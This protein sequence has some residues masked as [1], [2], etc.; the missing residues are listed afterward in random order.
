MTPLMKD[1][2][3]AEDLRDVILGEELDWNAFKL[4]AVYQCPYSEDHPVIKMFW[5]VFDEFEE[6]DKRQFLKFLTGADH[7]PVGGFVRFH[8]R[9]LN[10]MADKYRD[11]VVPNKFPEPGTLMPEV[12]T[13]RGFLSLDIP[14]YQT[15]E[16][17]RFRLKMAIQTSGFH[18]EAPH[19]SSATAPCSESPMLRQVVQAGVQL[20]L[21]G[22]R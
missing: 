7:V 6:N 8:V 9:R 10:N 17:L 14:E 4:S 18:R 5:K 1:I 13:C 2:F 21:G 15:K 20:L 22:R 3:K 19:R 16:D 11:P 12:M